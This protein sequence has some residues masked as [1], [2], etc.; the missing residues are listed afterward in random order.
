MMPRILIVGAGATGAACANIL[1]Q[2]LLQNVELVMWD[3]SKGTGGRMST[4]RSPDNNLCVAD[5]G[6]QY[7][8]VI[9]KYA[10]KHARYY[11]DLTTCGLLEPLTSKIDGMKSDSYEPG[12]KHYVAPKGIS[13][14]V[15]HFIK[16]SG[17]D[18]EFNHFLSKLD[19]VEDKSLSDVKLYA[20][21]HKEGSPDATWDS[22]K[23]FDAV[24]LT[25]P[26]PQLMK[27]P[28]TTQ[29]YLAQHPDTKQQLESA[30]Y[31]SRYALGLFFSPGSDIDVPWDATYVTGDPCIRWLAVDN[32]K[33]GVKESSELGASMVVHT[34]VPFGIKYLETDKN[35]VQGI[36]MEHLRNLV[37][38]LPEPASIKCQ[39]WRYSQVSTPVEGTPGCVF[40]TKLPSCAILATGDAFTHSNFDGCLSAAETTCEQLLAYLKET[41][42][43]GMESSSGL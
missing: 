15:K 36:V 39:K 43:V 25:M 30:C 4:S 7:V 42:Q 34:S 22:V 31:S 37:P 16:Q 32:R 24:I 29:E 26:L 17:I 27:L 10:E 20:S 38:N 6:A 41:G 3:K 13:S 8:T 12:T 40:L 18:V 1:R 11:K 33:R 2:R 28:G 9:P 5:L 19:T 35:E 14:L 23:P 21:G